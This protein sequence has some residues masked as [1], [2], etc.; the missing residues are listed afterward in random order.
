[1]AYALWERV[2]RERVARHLTKTD[3][4]A[5]IGPPVTRATIDRLR[6]ATRAPLARTVHQIADALDIPRDEA[7]LLAGLFPQSRA[8]SAASMHARVRREIDEDDS[9]TEQ[10]RSMLLYQ[11]DLFEAE[12]QARMNPPELRIV[13]QKGDASAAG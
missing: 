10:Q 4:A 3:L 9:L 2:E 12:H 5:L 13:P 1:M 8:E 11:L 6:T 7:E